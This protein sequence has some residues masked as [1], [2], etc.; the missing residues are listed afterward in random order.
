SSAA[1]AVL[2]AVAAPA[3]GRRTDAAGARKRSLFWLTTS[4]VVITAAL[5]FVQ[6]DWHFLWLGLVLMAA[7]SVIFELASVPYFAMLRQVSTPDD[8]GRVSGFGWAM[9]YFG[10]IILL[11]ICYFGFLAGDGDSRGVLGMPTDQGLNVRLVIVLAA[12]WFTVFA[13]PVLFAVPEMPRTGADPG[14]SE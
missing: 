8:V 14:R 3:L 11:L 1:G 9:G 13:L 6:D 10:G 2:I 5:F 4:V 12:V 7:G